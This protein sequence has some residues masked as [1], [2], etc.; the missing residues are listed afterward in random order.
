[1]NRFVQ[2]CIHKIECAF[3]FGLFVHIDIHIRIVS[4][5]GHKKKTGNDII[6]SQGFQIKQ[7][8]YV[9]MH[10]YRHIFTYITLFSVAFVANV[11]VH[12]IFK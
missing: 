3:S 2:K 1:M 9:I 12:M 7:S 8:L 6:M 11:E 10:L 5:Q 4:G